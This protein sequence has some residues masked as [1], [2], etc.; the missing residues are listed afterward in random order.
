MFKEN[1]KDKKHRFSRR[2]SQEK[3][4]LNEVILKNMS[5]MGEFHQRNEK[6]FLINVSPLCIFYQ[7]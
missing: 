3:W 7:F 4:K 1:N 6:T 2:R 5:I